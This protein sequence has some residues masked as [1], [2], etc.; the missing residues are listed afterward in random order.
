M[1]IVGGYFLKKNKL[2]VSFFILEL[3]LCQSFVHS[4]Y[5]VSVGEIFTYNIISSFWEVSLG[6]NYSSVSKCNILG[7]S[8]PVGTSFDIE[9]TSIT[10]EEACWDLIVG[11]KNYSSMNGPG[12]LGLIVSLL[13]NLKYYSLYFSIGWYQ[14]IVDK[15]PRLQKIFFIEITENSILDYLNNLQDSTFVSSEFF[16]YY[17]DFEQIA[18]YLEETDSLAIFD[19]V[20]EEKF[21]Y[22]DPYDIDITGSERFKIVFDKTTGVM[23]GYRIELNC[24]GKLDN[25][26]YKMNMNQEICLEN[27][28]LPEFYYS[29]PSK[30]GQ[31]FNWFIPVIVVFVFTI[32][33]TINRKKNTLI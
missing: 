14:E 4:N 21:E 2:L 25:Q 9:V 28:N 22:T 20:I 18:G 29:K 10:D 11:T 13:N 15:G 27:Y 33:V 16:N 26:K 30:L 7:D 32:V 8:Y 19:W 5:Q 17:E 1:C 24:S 12:D 3:V 31:G 23:K 6:S